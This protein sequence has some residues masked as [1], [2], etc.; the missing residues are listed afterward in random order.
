MSETI[1][2]L[3]INRVLK[4]GERE[5]GQ[6]KQIKHSER[7]LS[8]RLDTL[9][10]AGIGESQYILILQDTFIDS[11]FSKDKIWIKYV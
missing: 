9:Y 8:E 3:L 5:F 4:G 7:T 10:T 1:A 6:E 2:L 11:I